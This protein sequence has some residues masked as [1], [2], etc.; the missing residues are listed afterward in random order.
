MYPTVY[1]KQVYKSHCILELKNEEAKIRA[2]HLEYNHTPQ[3]IHRIGKT[4]N[5]LSILEKISSMKFMVHQYLVIILKLINQK[6][7]IVA[8]NEL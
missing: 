3:N 1:M 4:I 5:I 7:F 6:D 2:C 8:L